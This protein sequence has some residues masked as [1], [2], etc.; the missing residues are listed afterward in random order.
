VDGRRTEIAI[1]KLLAR[2][3]RQARSLETNGRYSGLDGYNGIPVP[4]GPQPHHGQLLF[5]SRPVQLSVTVRPTSIHMTCDGTT[6]VDWT[7]DPKR[8]IPHV[9]WNAIG[10][11]SL[12]LSSS[13]SV[14]I[15]EMTLTPL[16][17]ALP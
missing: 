12:F 13:T 9:H 4:Y 2:D 16:A 14:R 7:G 11:K 17:A 1:D 8:L 15:H 6:V 10:S 3:A 5:P